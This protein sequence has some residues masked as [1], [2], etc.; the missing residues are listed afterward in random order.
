MTAIDSRVDRARGKGKLTVHQGNLV[1][2][3]QNNLLLPAC[4][5]ELSKACFFCLPVSSVSAAVVR[6]F[7]RGWVRGAK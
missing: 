2:E 1:T 7:T 6:H 4:K 5:L 3:Q